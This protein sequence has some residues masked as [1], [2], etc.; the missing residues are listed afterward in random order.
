MVT[1]ADREAWQLSD[2]VAYL[3]VVLDAFGQDRLMF[4][5]DWP[6]CRQAAEYGA[7]LDVVESY[8]A[9]LSPPDQA[10]ILGETAMRWYRIGESRES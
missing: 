5:S 8:T 3:D 6:V 9:A 1:E 10:A 4:G 2:L 7:V